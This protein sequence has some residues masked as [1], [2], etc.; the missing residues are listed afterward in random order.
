[1]ADTFPRHQ[2][3]M[4]SAGSGKTYRLTH[5]YC[6]LLAKGVVPE[7]ILA[8]TFTRKA[9]GEFLD[10]ILQKLASA[11]EDEAYA[12]SLAEDF[13]MPH[14]DCAFFG[15]LLKGVLDALPRMTLG[16][17]DSF[18]ASIL[19]QFPMEFGLGG[20]YEMLDE[21]D[22][23]R[24]RRQI[25]QDVYQMQDKRTRTAF[26]QAF[27]NARWGQEDK[28]THRILETFI[29]D[30][31]KDVVAAPHSE[32]WGD[33]R[34]IWQGACPWN[35]P[36]QAFENAFQVYARAVSDVVIPEKTAMSVRAD[37]SELEGWKP[38]MVFPKSYLRFFERVAKSIDALKAGAGVFALYRQSKLELTPEVARAILTLRDAMVT[39][40]VK[41]RIVTT[42]G[43]YQLLADY[44]RR[45]HENIRSMGRLTFGD[46]LTL[47]N[48]A[49]ASEVSSLETVH[50]SLQYRLDAQFDHWLLDE[51][52]DTSYEQWSVLQPLLDEVLQDQDRGRTFFCVG[53]VKQ[54]IY[55]WRGG[56][57]RLMRELR[58][59]YAEVLQVAS[60]EESRRSSEEILNMV[61]GVFGNAETLRALFSKPAADEWLGD[62]N[63]HRAFEGNAHGYATFLEVAD[64][65]QTFEAVED[66]LNTAKPLE[67]GL[68]CAVLLRGNAAVT[69][70]VD[71][72]RGQGIPAVSASHVSIGTDN[73]LGLGLCALF[74]QAVHPADTL[75]RRYVEMS[76]LGAWFEQQGI[77]DAVSFVL[78]EV[79]MCGY[80]QVVQ[81]WAQRL[82]GLGCMD[83]FLRMRAKQITAAA[84]VFDAREDL[85]PDAFVAYL[86]ELSRSE[87]EQSGVVQVMTVH[88]SK[89]LGFD[90]VIIPELPSKDAGQW[91]SGELLVKKDAHRAV[92]WVYEP[93]VKPITL[94]DTHLHAEV[95][96]VLAE[97]QFESLCVWYVAMTRAKKALY[98][99]A[100]KPPKTRNA[101][102]SQLV[103]TALDQGET[104]E[105]SWGEVLLKQ[106]WRQGVANWYDAYAVQ[107]PTNEQEDAPLE[108]KVFNDAPRKARL[109]RR[110]PTGGSARGVALKVQA[111]SGKH[112]GSAV[113]QLFSQ[114]Q[115]LDAQTTPELDTRE[116][117]ER[118]AQ[119]AQ[120]LV[121]RVLAE[122]SVR[123]CFQKPSEPCVLWQEQ[124]FDVILDGVWMSGVFDRVHIY[125]TLDHP[126]RVELYDFK[127]DRVGDH[128]DARVRQHREQMQLY[129]CALSKM[130]N[131]PTESILGRLLFTD[132]AT[133]VK[134][135]F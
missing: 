8:L 124:A 31:H 30:R 82:D 15:K 97:R 26:I 95:E 91:P 116:L 128:L 94:V 32:Q 18:F 11:A 14:A 5:R 123:A 74:H 119:D 65:E 58:Q 23:P 100:E 41:R 118:F 17:L 112:F 69:A 115:W 3:I 9:A 101:S 73:A 27:K 67:R 127:T 88:K 25:F 133:L 102:M 64:K 37:L 6:Y 113:H 68:S 87:D 89:G 104:L 134:V 96:A 90:M 72:L 4:A 28:Q 99:F 39:G 10:A 105:L 40:E 42:Q 117:P 81:R 16:T 33:A 111:S 29:K 22:V 61:N 131:V 35:T 125:G 24:V 75:C 77:T 54:S 2:L 36:E 130:L 79:L 103:H 21:S 50:A 121:T 52:Q 108:S 98:V 60:M 132:T 84:R 51:F 20:G 45:Y 56:D 13:S 135:G 71:Y 122:A 7:T 83:D 38:G 1:M 57:P 76:P 49:A 92:Q 110:Q 78:E 46:V 85:H 106:H 80:A 114:V 47:L 120:T 93:P 43:V 107:M 19:R 34:S 86:I 55:S 59:R 66:L 48:K 62:W 70:Y 63:A 129:I 53:D 12:R 126:E 44:E 109:Q